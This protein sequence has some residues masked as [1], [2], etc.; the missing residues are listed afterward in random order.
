M[1]AISAVQSSAQTFIHNAFLFIDTSNNA[2]YNQAYRTPCLLIIASNDIF[3]IV[4]VPLP[5]VTF[6]QLVSL[7]RYLYFITCI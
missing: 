4:L 1:I 5:L 7:M 6:N 2:W 3:W